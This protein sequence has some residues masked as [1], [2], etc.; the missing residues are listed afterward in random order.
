MRRR[1][2]TSLEVLCVL[3]VFALVGQDWLAGVLDGRQALD[4]EALC[5]HVLEQLDG[6]ASDD[7]ALL[8]LRVA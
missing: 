3:L 7:V 2:V 5:D 8:V 6:P 4:P 1:R